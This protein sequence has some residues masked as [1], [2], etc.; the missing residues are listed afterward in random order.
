[1]VASASGNVARTVLI[2][3]DEP[4]VQ[5]LLTMVLQAESYH[6][7][8]ADDGE[9]ALRQIQHQK[10]DAMILDL[11]LPKLDGRTVVKT[12]GQDA[13]AELIPIITISAGQRFENVGE[14]GVKAF[15]SKPFDMDVLLV[16][17][18]EVLTQEPL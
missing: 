18:D 17:L 3:E 1:M 2:V 11:M 15:L 13:Q 7:E 8:T 5:A 12:L 16:V 10:P 6:V 9:E 14:Q 4:A